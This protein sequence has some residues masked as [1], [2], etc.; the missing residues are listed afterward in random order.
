MPVRAISVGV[1]AL[2]GLL[3]MGCGRESDLDVA[4]GQYRLHVEGALT[5]TLSGAAVL[6]PLRSGRTGIELGRREGPGLSIELTSPSR[7]DRRTAAS[8]RRISPG[9]YPVVTGTLLDAPASIRDSLSGVRVFLALAKTT[10]VAT[11][12][13]LSVTHAEDG[14]LDGSLTLEMRE[15][16]RTAT[17][18]RT[19]RVTGALRATTP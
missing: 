6:R 7:S 8:R 2:L 5:D 9:R 14:R 19:V 13:H 10:F 4:A 15:R 16:S 3:L 18:P 11:Q 12:G 17:A 1:V